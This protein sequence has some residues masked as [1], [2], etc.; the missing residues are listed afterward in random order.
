MEI[1]ERADVKARRAGVGR[2]FLEQRVGDDFHRASGTWRR[3]RRVID[4]EKNRYVETVTDAGG[5][6]VRDV[7][8][9][10]D[11]HRGHGSDATQQKAHP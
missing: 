8:V 3:I 9:P 7:D 1:H 11:E 6:V 4:R 2:P 5:Q 10:L